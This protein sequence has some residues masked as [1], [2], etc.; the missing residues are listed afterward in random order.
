MLSI[1]VFSATMSGNGL[2]P[3]DS[4]YVDEMAGVHRGRALW[5]PNCA[6]KVEIGDVGHIFAGRFFRIFNIHLPAGHQDQSTDLPEPFEPLV[7]NN[8][9]IFTDVLISGPRSSRSV[10]AITGHAGA[11]IAW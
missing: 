7:I 6:R 1:A 11:A 4:I 3:F 10:R 5:E 9:R 8:D 2:K